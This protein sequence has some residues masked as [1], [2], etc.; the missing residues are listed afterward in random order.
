MGINIIGGSALLLDVY[1]IG[2]NNILAI[3]KNNKFITK[4]TMK[5]GL[6]YLL[7]S[8]PYMPIHNININSTMEI[9]YKR[10]AYINPD[11]LKN[12]L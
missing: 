12:I 10:F 1:W 4:A 9:L 8:I 5:N 6:Y 2:N 7:A 3:T 11:N